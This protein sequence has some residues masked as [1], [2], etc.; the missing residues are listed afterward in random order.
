MTADLRKDIEYGRGLA[1]PTA[2]TSYYD[3]DGP[4]TEDAAHSSPQDCDDS[5]DLR[6]ALSSLLNKYSREN[7]SNTADWILRDFLWDCLK[8]FERG[9][10]QRDDWYGIRPEPGCEILVSK[11]QVKT[12]EDVEEQILEIDEDGIVHELPGADGG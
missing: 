1:G 3:S 10:G 7:V 9:V 5:E 11:T 2:L 12:P 4:E 8:A 6:T